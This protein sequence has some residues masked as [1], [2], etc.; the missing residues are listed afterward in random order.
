MLMG[1][2]QPALARALRSDTVW[3]IQG[4]SVRLHFASL[5]CFRTGSQEP[6]TFTGFWGLHGNYRMA[7]P[8]ADLLLHG[9]PAHRRCDGGISG[10]RADRNS[11]C[12]REI[13]R[14]HV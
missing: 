2:S 4:F 5:A 1:L 3:L 6:V 11:I 14:A 8:W 7:W 12:N 13:G 10:D 9:N